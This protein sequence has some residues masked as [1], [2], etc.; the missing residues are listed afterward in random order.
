MQGSD[1]GLVL[2]CIFIRPIYD[3]EDLITYADDNYAGGSDEDL[4]AAIMMVKTK[5][6]KIT[7]WMTMS[8]LKINVAKTEICIFHR[9]NKLLREIEIQGVNITTKNKMNIFC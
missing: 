6:E 4:L 7:T 5:M 3:L 2:F 8:G 9:R 1:P